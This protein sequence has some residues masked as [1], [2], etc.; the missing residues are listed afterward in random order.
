MPME[1]GYFEAITKDSGLN[2]GFEFDVNSNNTGNVSK[3]ERSYVNLEC[4][5]VQQWKETKFNWNQFN[6]EIH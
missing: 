4:R 3:I 1:T 6:G 2:F 5:L